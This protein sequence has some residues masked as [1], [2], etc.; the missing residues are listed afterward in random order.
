MRVDTK[1]TLLTIVKWEE[2]EPFTLNDHYFQ[3]KARVEADL[4]DTGM[5]DGAAKDKIAACLAYFEV[6]CKLELTHAAEDC[7]CGGMATIGCVHIAK[8]NHLSASTG[9]GC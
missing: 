5:P 3:S 7:Q 8:C 9:L 2:E 4:T 6:K 1:E